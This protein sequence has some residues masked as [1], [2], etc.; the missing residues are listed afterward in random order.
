MNELVQIELWHS[1]AFRFQ[2][3]FFEGYI[4]KAFKNGFFKVFPLS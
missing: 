2:D 1:A 3:L 4:I